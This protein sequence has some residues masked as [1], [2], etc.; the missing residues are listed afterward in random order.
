MPG[1][2]FI[3]PGKEDTIVR[4]L[5]AH[6]A[7]YRMALDAGLRLALHT[8]ISRLIHHYNL[9]HNQLAPDSWQNILTLLVVCELKGVNPSLVA[10]TQIHYVYKV[11]KTVDGVW[12]NICNCHGVLTSWD[13]TSKMHAR[14]A[15]F[16]FVLAESCP[17]L[18]SGLTSRGRSPSLDKHS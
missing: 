15:K 4:A 1:Y 10:F 6:F 16:M 13:K 17:K 18:K 7:V 11:P 12:F 14:K 3:Q 2:S 8:F 9:D 5:S